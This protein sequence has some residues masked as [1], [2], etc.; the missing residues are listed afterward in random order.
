MAIEAVV[1]KWG[2]SLGIVLP[3]SFVEEKGLKKNQKLWIEIAPIV[4]FSEIFGS[5]KLGVSSQELKDEARKG[6]D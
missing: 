3:K 2:S 1:R 6:W 5:C 4:D